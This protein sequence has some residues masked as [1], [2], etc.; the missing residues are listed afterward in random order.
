[1]RQHH[2]RSLCIRRSLPPLPSLPGCTLATLH[3]R[4]AA[5]LPAAAATALR[6]SPAARAELW[7]ALTAGPFAAGDLAATVR[8][9]PAGRAPLGP[10]PSPSGRGQ[11]A[12]GAG[13]GSGRPPRAPAPTASH[14][15]SPLAAAAAGDPAA[16]P[17]ITLTPSLPAWRGVVGLC[18]DA[19]SP[20]PL[21]GRA[22]DAL[23]AIGRARAA[24]VLRSDLGRALGVELKNFHFVVNHLTERGAAVATPVVA[25]AA[26][27]APTQTTSRL[28]LPR[29][30]P[31]LTGG[32]ALREGW[33]VGG[34]GGPEGEGEGEGGAVP[35]AVRDDVSAARAVIARLAAI[36]PAATPDTDLK[37]MLG[38]PKGAVGA[39]AWRR[40]RGLMLA[41]GYARQVAIARVGGAD[42]SGSA[43]AAAPTGGPG[44]R[45]ALVAA[46]AW[47]DGAALVRAADPSAP[48]APGRAGTPEAGEEGG[49]P[50]ALGAGA[51]LVPPACVRAAALV[52]EAGTD[53]HFLRVML[54]A[55]ERGIPALELPRLM[56]LNAKKAGARAARAAGRFGLAQRGA[57]VGRNVLRVWAAPAALVAAHRAAFPPDMPAGVGGYLGAL[58]AAV[59][60]T[61]LDTAGW[62]SG[63]GGG[64]G[65]GGS[66][67]AAAA[68]RRRPP[69]PAGGAGRQGGGGGRC[70]SRSCLRSRR[71]RPSPGPGPGGRGGP[72][73][74][75]RGRGLGGGRV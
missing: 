36:A 69:T 38:L 73:R 26:P 53:A 68:A 34:G 8:P 43:A 59:R 17:A 55:G 71:A 31:R 21:S 41:A 67:A 1:M 35:P 60:G 5:H 15:A 74:P 28:H 39:R 30:A 62:G 37:A 24:G 72:G 22:L 52:A 23:E 27:G 12:S 40:L 75:G 65:G 57:Q 4:L 18:E 14:S 19:L 29:F 47:D 32:Q 49:A 63:S 10:S 66:S 54:A 58:A 33:G 20:H 25:R 11:G 7:A 42:A 45:L 3:D 50:S 70:L 16:L 13:R 48:A 51:S 46:A 2:P 9:P 44:E 64:G 61:P 6:E 56:G